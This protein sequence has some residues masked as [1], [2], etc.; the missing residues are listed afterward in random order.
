M[1]EYDQGGRKKSQAIQVR[2]V[3]F[4]FVHSGNSCPDHLL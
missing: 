3:D 4:L 1:V 2:E